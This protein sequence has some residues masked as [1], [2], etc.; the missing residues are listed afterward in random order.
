MPVH[1]QERPRRE[2]GEPSP[3]A[4]SAGYSVAGAN[5]EV[6]IAA[7]D[8]LTTADLRI[9]WRKLYRATPP[10]RLSRDLLIRGIAYRLQEEAH[11]GLI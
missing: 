3:C 5:V 1:Q 2:A 10:T 9:E 8:A 6:R 11:G 7:L 4:D